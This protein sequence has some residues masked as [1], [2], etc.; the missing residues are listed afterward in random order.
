M[1]PNSNPA[2]QWPELPVAVVS[3]LSSPETRPLLLD[4]CYL[5]METLAEHCQAQVAPLL[6]PAFF[7]TSARLLGDAQVRPE[8]KENCIA[9]LVS[10]IA[11][12]DA[13]QAVKLSPQVVKMFGCVRDAIFMPDC[14][15]GQLPGCAALSFCALCGRCGPPT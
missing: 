2:A 3:A 6:K 7:E 13:P 8:L 1:V 12:L 10:L 15:G 5:V 4:S 9:A 11:C 14:N